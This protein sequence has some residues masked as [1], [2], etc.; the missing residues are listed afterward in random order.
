[1]KSNHLFHQ[2]GDL[3]R[4]GHQYGLMNIL[5]WLRCDPWMLL[6]LGATMAYGLLILYSAADQQVSVIQ[7]QIIRILVAS[8]FMFAFA[9]IP[10]PKLRLWS[11]WIFAVSIVLLMLV[12]VLGDVG[13]GAQR[14]LNLGFMRFQP[15]EMAKLA[16]PMMLAWYYAS[17]PLPPTLPQIS[18][19]FVIILI[20]V[21]LVVRQPDLGTGVMIAL[22]GLSVLF[23]AGLAWWLIAGG[24]IGAVA[25][26]PVLWHA[27][28]DYQKQRVLTFLN[29]ERDPLG[30]GY[31]IIQSKIAI[32]SGGVSGK[33]WL[34]GTQSR[35]HFLPENTTDFIFSVCAEDFGLIGASIL[36]GLFLLIAM[37]AFYIAYRAHDS[38]CRLLAGSLAFM[39]FGSC[40]VN[41]GMV[42]GL[43]PVVGLPLPL[44]SY[45]GTSLV[46]IMASFGILM[47]IYHHKHLWR[48]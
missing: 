34:E 25:A 4:S 6:L 8:V 12:M 30:A 22:A 32:G 29:P 28:H 27:M 14:W 17:K 33:G 40:F 3:S 19:G 16:L 13:K 45:G 15:S 47:S 44:I 42:T 11:P 9:Q 26:F 2:H 23:L 5:N 18:L 43:L 10:P 20:P 41:I 48:S 36:I 7:K 21:M 46:T 38:F 37:R 31:H 24:I 39:F 1:M 35:L